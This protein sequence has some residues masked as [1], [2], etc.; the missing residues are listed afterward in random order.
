MKII[1]LEA[2]HANIDMI[3]PRQRGRERE[4]LV[5]SY[6]GDYNAWLSVLIQW[7]PDSVS[8]GA[9]SHLTAVVRKTF[10]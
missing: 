6:C 9:V 5:A 7:T 4:E 1:Q 8:T 10:K 2:A 3:E